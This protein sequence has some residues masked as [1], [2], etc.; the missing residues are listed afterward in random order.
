MNE[1]PESGIARV[2]QVGE[3]PYKKMKWNS[4]NKEIESYDNELVLFQH[5]QQK[6]TY[7]IEFNKIEL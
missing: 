7:F 3:V 1:S 4:N 6:I 5:N 2:A